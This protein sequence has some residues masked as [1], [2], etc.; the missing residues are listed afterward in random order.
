MKYIKVYGRECFNKYGK[1]FKEFSYYDL[2][3]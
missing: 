3:I 2:I 1:V